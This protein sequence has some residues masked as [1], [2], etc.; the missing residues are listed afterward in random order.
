M[1]SNPSDKL[2]VHKRKRYKT[3][4]KKSTKHI[5]TTACLLFG[6][7]C[8]LTAPEALAQN[9][10]YLHNGD[11]VSGAVIS[12]TPATGNQDGYAKI[13]TPHGVLTI[14]SSQIHHIEQV[15]K[16]NI[17]ARAVNKDTQPAHTTTHS[18]RYS[19]NG[20][21]GLS[22]LA[23]YQQNTSLPTET[24]DTV[25][26]VSPKP[27]TKTTQTEQVVAPKETPTEKTKTGTKWSGRANL[28]A[29]LRTGTSDQSAVNADASIK[30]RWNEYHR[31]EFKI[32]IAREED[33]G[34]I[35][36]DQ[37]RADILHDY[38]FKP[39]WF[40]NA[41]QGLERDKIDELDLRSTTN[42][43]IGHQAWESDDLNLKYVFGPSYI[44]EEFESGDSESDIAARWSLD[45]DQK[46]MDGLFQIFHEHTLSTPVDNINHYIL[47]TKTGARV[48]LR[49]GLVATGQ[50]DYDRDNDPAAGVD[51][52]TARYSLKL[53]YE[54]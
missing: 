25:K 50:I 26:A 24:I 16:T 53:G 47:R 45:Y 41:G 17:P 18:P 44:Y 38:F 37:Q 42:I 54:W 22:G 14:P 40:L 35:T 13:Q 39:D 4:M 30:A 12:Q 49:Q 11:R 32:D 2:Y 1:L 27:V 48:P 6:A 36:V 21:S 23:I 31:S 3:G 8:L 19:E 46:V 33:D 20:F 28:G 15:S 51:T 43:G 34:S 7:V 5:K 9:V 52:D 10:I 29:N